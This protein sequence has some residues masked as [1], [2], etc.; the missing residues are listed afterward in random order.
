MLPPPPISS[1][2]YPRVPCTALFRSARPRPPP[3]RGRKPRRYLR[4]VLRSAYCL[5]SCHQPGKRLSGVIHHGNDACIVQPCRSDNPH[6]ADNLSFA[7]KIW[8]GD[9]ARAGK[10]EKLVFRADENLHAVA[11]PRAFQ[12][13]DE[14]RRSDERRVGKEW[15]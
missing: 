9:D 1:R 14:N 6:Y 13:R 15:V 10:R 4:S 5:R 7:A 11:R 12:T 3:G 8:G 2:P